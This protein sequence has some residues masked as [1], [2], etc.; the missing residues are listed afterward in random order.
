[1]LRVTFTSPRWHARIAFDLTVPRRLGN[2]YPPVTHRTSSTIPSSWMTSSSLARTWGDCAISGAAGGA[3]DREVGGPALHSKGTKPCPRGIRVGGM[4]RPAF[5]KMCC[6]SSA[7]C[8]HKRRAPNDPI[9][10]VPEHPS[11]DYAHC[12]RFLLAYS[13]PQITVRPG[14]PGPAPFSV[15]HASMQI[16]PATTPLRPCAVDVTPPGAAVAEGEADGQLF[17]LWPVS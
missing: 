11:S 9:S 2:R 10:P 1:M 16:L 12:S 4:G 14:L 5:A 8:A 6:V 13:V 7:K 15:S 17:G 3:V